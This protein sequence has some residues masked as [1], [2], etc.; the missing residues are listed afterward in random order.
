MNCLV[1]A[2]IAVLV[3]AHPELDPKWLLADIDRV[4]AVADDLKPNTTQGDGGMLDVQ[5][6]YGFSGRSVRVQLERCRA[7][8]SLFWTVLLQSAGLGSYCKTYYDHCLR[9]LCPKLLR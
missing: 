1:G 8:R 7:E 3:G 9:S 6:G 4:P 2:G 5:S